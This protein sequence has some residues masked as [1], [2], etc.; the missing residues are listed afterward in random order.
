VDAITMDDMAYNRA[1]VAANLTDTCQKLYNNVAGAKFQPNTPDFLNFTEAIEASI[2]SPLGWC[3]KILKEKA[4]EFGQPNPNMTY[5]RI[6]MGV[7]QGDSPGVP[8]VMEIWPPGHYS[9]VH[10]HAGANAVIRVLHGKITVNLYQMLSKYHLEPFDV[11]KF[12]KD[13]VT[14][15]SP[16]LN[17]TH[18]LRNANVADPTY[19]TIQCYMYGE[20]DTQHYS[21]FDYLNAQGQE[22]QFDPNSDMDYLPFKE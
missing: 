5:L 11:A 6:A 8:F 1:T 17:Q 14:W 4:N 18:Q 7:N 19:I 2:A 21:Y 9:S 16:D 12:G 20:G 15:I 3:N 22:E 10:N 13:D